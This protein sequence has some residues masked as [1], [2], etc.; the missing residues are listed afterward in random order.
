MYLRIT[1]R[2]NADGSVVRYAALAHN[3]RVEG[4]VK[5]DVLMNLGRVDQLDVDG[6]RGLAASITKHFGDSEGGAGSA[7][8]HS[9]GVEAGLAAGRRRWRFSIPA[10]SGRP[11]YRRS[12]AKCFTLRDNGRTRCVIEASL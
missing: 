10:R 3:R 12:S 6:L 11:G 9:D 4:K 8:G 5:P 7:P 2:T 1:Q